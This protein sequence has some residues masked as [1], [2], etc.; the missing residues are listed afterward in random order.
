[1]KFFGNTAL[2]IIASL[3]ISPAWA[4]DINP[5]QT[6][7]SVKAKDFSGSKITFPGNLTGASTYVLFLAMSETRDN[8]Q[9][10]MDQLLEW[11]SSIDESGG[12]P[13]DTKGYHYPVMESPPFFVKGIISSAMSDGY[14]GRVSPEQSGVLFVDDLNEFSAAAGLT[15]DDQPTVVIV[16][17]GKAVAQLKGTVN[18]ERLEELYTLLKP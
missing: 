4:E 6:F 15:L 17:S 12:L 13:N 16:K 14:E 5:A 10:Q 7:P 11:Q 9:V 2:A 18:A 3:F 8:G 1:M